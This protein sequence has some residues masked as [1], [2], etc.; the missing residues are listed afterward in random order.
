MFGKGRKI[1]IEDINSQLKIF[2]RKIR[3]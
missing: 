1:Q 2:T 3:S